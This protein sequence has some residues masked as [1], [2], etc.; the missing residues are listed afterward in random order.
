MRKEDKISLDEETYHPLEPH[1]HQ[2][3]SEKRIE[4]LDSRVSRMEA[5]LERMSLCL[6]KA[7]A[8]V[9][10]EK[11]SLLKEY[12]KEE[13]ESD[14]RI[15][16]LE[17]QEKKLSK[18]IA[19]LEIEENEIDKRMGYRRKQ[20]AWFALV[21]LDCKYKVSEDHHLTCTRTG[22]RCNYSNCPLKGEVDEILK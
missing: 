2:E 14:E 17:S 13:K 7:L 22:K 19:K 1:E 8:E 21:M 10:G 18:E 6:K 16:I 3:L 11:E 5:M 20:D 9:K 4:K 12:E 15:K